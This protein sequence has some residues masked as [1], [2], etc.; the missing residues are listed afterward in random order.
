MVNVF[1]TVDTEVWP[2]GTIWR[3]SG[4]TRDIDR[5][6][7]GITP[8]GE[9][10]VRYQMD[11][12]DA[13]Q[14]KAVF[15]VEAL[16]ALAVGIEPLKELVKTI[17]AR[18]HEV[19]LH[20][21]TEWLQWLDPS[22]LPGRTGQNISDFSVDE[23]ALLLAK[24]LENLKAS[25]AA[26]VCAFRAG[27]Y[28]ANLD[29]LHALARNGIRYDTSHNTC[30]LD[31]ECRMGEA[32]ILL[33]PKI[34]HGVHEFPVSFF[35]DWPGHFR[36]T[37]L[38]A[39]SADEME[40]ALLAA[41]QDGWESFVIVSHSFELIRDRKHPTKQPRSDRRVIRRFD[42]LCDFLASNRDKFQT[43]G[44]ASMPQIPQ[45]L[46]D[47]PLRSGLHRTARRVGEQLLRRVT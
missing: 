3:D 43:S 17:E 30:Y 18:G 31:A 39:C 26:N 47:H 36:H 24:G 6:I 44:F 27:N 7:Y 38:C 25:G 2:R 40:H 9:F 29:T 28:G 35:Q 10:G 46:P 34:I 16:F 20:L 13:H 4:L 37:Q 15:F 5:D 12:L 41:W 22:P 42:R 32:G 14:L 23:Q 8:E 19:Q 33:G 11:V 45:R 1:I 21:H